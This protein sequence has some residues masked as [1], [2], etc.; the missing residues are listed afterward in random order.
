MATLFSVGDTFLLFDTVNK[1]NDLLKSKDDSPSYLPCRLAATVVV[2]TMYQVTQEK[3]L[4]W[5]QL[6]ISETGSDDGQIIRGDSGPADQEP[7]ERREH[8][9]D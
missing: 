7:Q 3:Y 9:Q 6:L 8:R 5:L 2:G 4:Q 1:F